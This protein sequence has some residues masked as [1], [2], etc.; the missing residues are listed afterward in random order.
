MLFMSKFSKTM[1]AIA[2][3]ALLAAPAAALEFD[4]V[5]EGRNARANLSGAGCSSDNTNNI[6][7]VAE[8]NNFPFLVDPDLADFT[9]G[10]NTGIWDAALF[11]FNNEVDAEGTFVISRNGNT[12]TDAPKKAAVGVSNDAFIALAQTVGVYAASE[13]SRF[14]EFLDVTCQVTRGEAKWGRNGDRLNVKMDMQCMY[15]D[16]REK[17]RNVWLR[18]NSGNLDRVNEQ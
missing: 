6:D 2:V 10:P 5:W 15:L 11:I 9:S 18:I 3:S 17:T 7:M 16:D 8:M 1:A 12:A 14:V 4:E 13:C